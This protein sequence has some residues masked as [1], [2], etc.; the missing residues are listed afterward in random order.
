IRGELP[1][2][3]YRAFGERLNQ[4]GVLAQPAGPRIDPVR[5]QCGEAPLNLFLWLRNADAASVEIDFDS[6]AVADH[7]QWAAFGRFRHDLADCYAAIQSRE[8]SIGDN[9]DFRTKARADKSRHEARR[10]HGSW[11]AFHAH[12]PQHNDIARF[13]GVLS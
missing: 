10:K 8:F 1:L 12:H 2:S 3:K 13:D 7:S 6:V 9:G 11:A 5:G 4:F